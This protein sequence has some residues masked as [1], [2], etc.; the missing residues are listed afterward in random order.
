[1]GPTSKTISKSLLAKGAMMGSKGNDLD[2]KLFW[3]RI[4]AGPV[5]GAAWI[6]D[7]ISR[8]QWNGVIIAFVIG[9]LVCPALGYLWTRS[10]TK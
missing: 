1:M 10:S 3:K 5:V 7:E 8:H 4:W 9:F 2:W 6:L